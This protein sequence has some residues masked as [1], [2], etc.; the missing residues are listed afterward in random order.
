MTR[1]LVLAGTTEATALAGALAARAVDVVSSLAG[2][3]TRPAGRAGRVRRGGFGGVE[4][5]CTYLRDE[6]I[7][8]LVDATHPFAAQMPFHAAAAAATVGVPVLRLLRPPWTA[9]PGDRWHRVPSLEAAAAALAELGARRV[10]LAVGGQRAS[11]FGRCVGVTFVARAIEPLGDALPGATVVLDR[12]P[13]DTEAERAL[14][15]AHDIDTVVAKNAGGLATEAK[16]HAARALGL[17]VVLVDRP[18]QPAVP[19][20]PDVPAA[21]A[22]L[23]SRGL[24]HQ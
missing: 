7:D 21:L 17:T 4:G 10:F 15:S 9:G 2:V 12:G 24:L 11:A 20:V 22:W 18:P 3:T 19:A 5:L 1:V 8:A 13:F 6:H 23:V 16:L 14:L